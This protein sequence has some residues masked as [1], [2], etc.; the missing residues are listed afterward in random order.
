MK[1]SASRYLLLVAISVLLG[2]CQTPPPAPPAALPPTAGQVFA[3]TLATGD[4]NTAESQLGALQQSNPADPDLDRYQHDL[5]AAWLQLSQRSLQKGDLNTAATALTHARSLMP[6]AP[7]LTS[8]VNGAIANARKAELDRA[9]AEL[10]AASKPKAQMIDPTAPHTFVELD[11]A[12]PA[13]LRHQLDAIAADAVNFN[14]S[15]VVQSPRRDDG[16]WLKGLLSA[17][18]KKINSDYVPQISSKVYRS[19]PA[20]LLIS[21]R[22]D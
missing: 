11:T 18:M 13:K 2:A 14:A 16:P 22:L 10:A 4:L 7:A 20:R 6:K 21:P 19:Q 8:G 12:H 17:R 9:E 5:A 1:P 15:I 3:Q